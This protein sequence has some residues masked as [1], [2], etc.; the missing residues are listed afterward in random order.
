MDLKQALKVFQLEHLEDLGLDQIKLKYRTL[1][2]ETH[3]D[4]G[5]DSKAFIEIQ[6]AYNILINEYDSQRDPSLK[7][8]KILSKEEILEKYY[9]DKKSFEIEIS[10]LESAISK[11]NQIVNQTFFQAKKLT[12]TYNQVTEKVQ[13]DFEE[14]IN[15]LHS[16]YF[17]SAWKRL[18]FFWNLKKKTEF[19]SHL[20]H[21]ISNYQNVLDNKYRD[22]LTDLNNIY[23]KGFDD[24][25]IP[26]DPDSQL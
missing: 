1:A 22:Y 16:D 2:R 5:G 24:L 14:K 18:L 12:N 25:N 23:S 7:E 6:E 17:P 9:K 13:S 20:N 8:L 26:S 21:L 10:Q 15:K 3:P 4:K 11:K 19:E